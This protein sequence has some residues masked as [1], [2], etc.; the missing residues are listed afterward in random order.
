VEGRTIKPDGAVV[1]LNKDAIFYKDVVRKNGLKVRVVSFAM[2][3]VEPGATI[4][5]PWKADYG[6]ALMRFIPLDV[7]S[8]FPTDELIFHV[9]PASSTQWIRLPEMHY[10][11]FGCKID[12]IKHD[13]TGFE[14][15]TLHNIPAFHEEPYTPPDDV[16]KQWVLLYYEENANAEVIRIGFGRL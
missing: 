2:P 3:G 10:I 15:V 8:E 16:V 13:V 6:E 5:Y 1:E 9:K 12:S 7:Q 11:P 4:E 14:T